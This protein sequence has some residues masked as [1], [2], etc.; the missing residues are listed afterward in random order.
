MISIF[1]IGILPLTPRIRNV[2]E[3]QLIATSWDSCAIVIFNN[4]YFYI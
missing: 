4:A 1:L 2:I 3:V